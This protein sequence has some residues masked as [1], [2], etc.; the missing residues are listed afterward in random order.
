MDAPPPVPP[1]P[2]PDCGAPVSTAFCS[3]CG[4]STKIRRR[5]LWLVISDFFAHS[6]AFDG[7]F[8]RT[9]IP[10]LIKPGWVTEQNLKERWVSFLPPLRMYLV[11]SVV[12]FLMLG[13]V[14]PDRTGAL[15][16]A[17]DSEGVV[18]TDISEKDVG[19][20]PEGYII[21]DYFNERT[22]AKIEKLNEMEPAVR[23]YALYKAAVRAIPTT[24]LLALPLFAI[25]MKIAYL[26]RRRYFFD[27]FVFATHF[28]SAWLLVLG[29]SLVINQ[30]W[31]WIVG[32]AV[33]LPIYLFL[34]LKRVYQ[35]HWF[36]TIFKMMLLGIWQM[37]SSGILAMTVLL[38]AFFSV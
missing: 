1:S 35:Q 22:R 30:T 13:S 32:H 31:L 24:L 29:P 34:A 16:M 17:K 28:Y 7:R 38:S 2:C 5:T 36:L 20:F 11:I 12:F 23:D 21:T 27:H 19:L 37:F 33:Y 6:F 26:L 9:L 3:A 10:L 14:L 4:Q 8:W 15:F 25:G 18:T